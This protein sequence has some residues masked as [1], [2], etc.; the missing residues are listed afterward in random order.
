M[1]AMGSVCA[2]LTGWAMG[3]RRHL[4]LGPGVCVFRNHREQESQRVGIT[5]EEEGMKILLF[6]TEVLAAE[7]RIFASL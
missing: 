2:G 3:R 7:T 4:S 6:S 1:R 5:E